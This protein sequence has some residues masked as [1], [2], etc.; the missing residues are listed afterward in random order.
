MVVG[1]NEQLDLSTL[2][3]KSDELSICVTSQDPR[4]APR[5]LQPLRA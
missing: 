2:Y 1:S 5:T 3:P 4:V